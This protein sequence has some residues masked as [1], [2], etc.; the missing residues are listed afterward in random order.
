MLILGRNE[1]ATILFRL[2][3]ISIFSV[4][5]TAISFSSFQFVRFFLQFRPSSLSFFFLLWERARITRHACTRHQ[6]KNEYKFIRDIV[7]SC[8]LLLLLL[9]LLVSLFFSFIICHFYP[10]WSWRSIANVRKNWLVCLFVLL[11][12][13]FFFFLSFVW[14]F[15]SSCA[16]TPAHRKTKW[17]PFDVT[18]V[19]QFKIILIFQFFLLFSFFFFLFL[20]CC[21]IQ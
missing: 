3:E 10:L 15:F 14:I 18:R 8:I 1:A 4:E 13:L 16:R 21:W 17:P 2:Q 6:L 5:D 20:P 11:L 19:P 9:L 12:L 7:Y